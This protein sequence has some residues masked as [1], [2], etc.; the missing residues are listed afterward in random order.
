MDENTCAC[1]AVFS[2]YQDKGNT[3]G[4]MVCADIK[5]VASDGP[6]NRVCG[7]MDIG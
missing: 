5:D 6:S 3:E 2:A 1:R 4:A 7:Y